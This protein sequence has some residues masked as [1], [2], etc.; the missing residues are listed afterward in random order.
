MHILYGASPDARAFTTM[1][2]AARHAT[3]NGESF[4]GAMQELGFSFRLPF[5]RR[6]PAGVNRQSKERPSSSDAAAA[7]ES[8]DGARSKILAKF[9]KS[10]AVDEGDMWGA[11]RA[12]RRAHRTFTNGL[13][14][15]WPELND[16]RPPARAVRA[17]GESPATAPLRDLK[18]FLL[19][20]NVN[21]TPHSTP[22]P[23]HHAFAPTDVDDP[24]LHTPP[25][26][27]IQ[28]RGA[29]LSFAPDDPTFRAAILL[30]GTVRA[31]GEIPLMLA[32][33]RGL[34]ITPHRRTLAYALVFWA[35][36]SVGAPLLERFR[37]RG[38]GGGGGSG[39][40][41]RGGGGV[42]QGQGEY[43]RLLRWMEEWVGAEK[44]P[45]EAEVGEAMRRVDLMRRGRDRSE[46]PT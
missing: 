24:D 32:W 6:P 23:L 41:G 40:G 18:H 19:P 5:T 46:D 9:R 25:L 4:A 2:V 3:L 42:G 15:G 26:L 21:T 44:V 11:E 30:L 8:L 7:T 20:P 45:D 16:V 12:W 17:S 43:V 39:S 10:F 38:G 1:L 37:S 33:M 35:E 27:P 36:V 13:L 31:A 28:P 14:A 29:H 22:P 34:G